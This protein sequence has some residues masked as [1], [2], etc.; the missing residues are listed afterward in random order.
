MKTFLIRIGGVETSLGTTYPFYINVSTNKSQNVSI[1]SLYT[2][3]KVPSSYKLA[4]KN[5]LIIKWTSST[6]FCSIHI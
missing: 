4:I 2:F 5:I 3:D 6:H 1:T